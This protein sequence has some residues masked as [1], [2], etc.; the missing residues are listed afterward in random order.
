MKLKQKIAVDYLRLKFKAFSLLSKKKAAEK[1]FELFRTPQRR[2]KKEPSKIFKEAENVRFK[3]EGFFIHGYRWNKGRSKKVLI[4]HGFESSIINFEQYVRPLIDKGYEVLAFDAPAHGHSSGDMITAPLFAAMITKIYQL[5]GPIQSFIA[6]SFGGL[7]LSIALEKL[8]PSDGTKIVFIAPLTEMKTAIDQFFHFVK[9]NVGVRKE[10]DELIA[11]TGDRPVE[12]Y[13][14]HRAIKT[15]SAKILW[16]HDEDDE[17]TP[18]S[19]ALKV[20]EENLPD[21]KFIITKG[22]GHRK[23][24]RDQKIMQ[25]IIDFL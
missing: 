2:T 4:V 24:Y 21:V 20:K 22:L 7:V 12:W 9:L 19:D 5:Y 15:I 18:L 13:S 25:E 10:F 14:T 17:Q 23:I 3:L 1:A 16:I 6:H 11:N 8:Q